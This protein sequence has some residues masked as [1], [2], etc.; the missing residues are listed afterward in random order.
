MRI[1]LLFLFPVW[2]VAGAQSVYEKGYFIDR[3]NSFKEAYIK[4]EDWRS[5]GHLTSIGNIKAEPVRTPLSEV[6]EF[7]IG[8]YLK[9][10][11]TTVAIDISGDE[12]AVLSYER[13]PEWHT[14]ELFLRVLVVGNISLF[15]F[16]GDGITRFFYKEGD[17]A[18]VQLVNKRYKTQTEIAVND[19]FRGVLFTRLNCSD[20][21]QS[22][23]NRMPYREE[24]LVQHVVAENKCRGLQP[25]VYRLPVAKT[26]LEV[27]TAKGDLYAV[28]KADTSVTDGTA[29]PGVR[30][31]KYFGI[32]INPLIR[33]IVDLNPEN[34]SNNNLF[35][36]QY[37]IN[38]SRTG[39]GVNFGLSYGRSTFDDQSNNTSRI[40][41][42]RSYSFRFGYERKKALGKK[43]IALHG[44]DFLL[45]NSKRKTESFLNAVTVHVES[46]SKGWG[47]GPRVGLLY[48][49]GDKIF[50]GT[51]ASLYFQKES[52]RQTFTNQQD[53]NQKST[54]TG[55][56]L[57]TTLFLHVQ[58]R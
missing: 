40:T 30:R 32:E 51:E 24:A 36:I 9:M 16:E 38:S 46:K 26:V 56:T 33:Q 57:P 19:S 49:L 42:D 8:N 20:S 52:F 2:F 13:E 29:K 25:V 50:L 3:N 27:S 44:Y 53:S 39:R 7:G 37:A 1:T 5:Q 12:D 48:R 22:Y 47:L 35:S 18:I 14:E 41:L 4:I 21:A 15:V 17:S 58:L 34:N 45:T 28:N 23:F 43:W 11:R 10:M 55:I 54:F 6:N 31:N